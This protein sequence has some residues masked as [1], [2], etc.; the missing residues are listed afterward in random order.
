MFFHFSGKKTK[1]ISS[2]LF[3]CMLNIYW[4]DQIRLAVFEITIKN[5]VHV[6]THVLISSWSDD[7]NTITNF[8][9]GVHKINYSWK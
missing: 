6:V 8:Y 5:L 7:Y 1:E 4:I 2:K 9:K 3:Q